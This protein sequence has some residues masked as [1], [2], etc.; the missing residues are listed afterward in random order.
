[1]K[2][3]RIY[4]A[5]LF[6]LCSSTAFAND[7]L[8]SFVNAVFTNKELSSAE[9]LKAIDVF[10]QKKENQQY[11][12]EQSQFYH[13][14]S[15]IFYSEKNLPLAISS[16]YRAVEIRRTYKNTH[17]EL[18]KKSLYNLG[19]FHRK[20]DETLKSIEVHKEILNE[21][22]EDR[23]SAKVYLDLGI[24]YT[25]IGDFDK[26]LDYFEYAKNY[27]RKNNI[28]RSLF[29]T[30]LQI[31]YTYTQMDR[32][33]YA[34]EILK[35]LRL[36]DSIHLNN[37]LSIMKENESLVINLRK[38]NLFLE[39]NKFEK[40]QESLEKAL[41][42][43][44][45]YND[46]M[47]LAYIH[48][49]L[50]KLHIDLKDFSKA[51]K[52]FE[53]SEQF[54]STNS[55]RALLSNMRA[56]LFTATEKWSMAEKEHLKAI[57]FLTG[58][59]NGTLP[60]ISELNNL[61]NKLD[62]LNYIKDL[63]NFY[64]D[65]H[66]VK[67]NLASLKKALNGFELADGLLDII[68]L[69]STE[70][71]SKLFWREQG[72]EVYLKGVKAAYLLNLPEKGFHF[73][74]KGKVVLLLEDL[75]EQQAKTLANIP[76]S[77]RLSE[78]NFKKSIINAEMLLVNSKAENRT[79]VIRDS[80]FKIKQDFQKFRDELANDFPKYA[81]IRKQIEILKEPEVA[82]KLLSKHTAVVEFVLDSVDGYAY[83]R[84]PNNR[85]FVKLD[86]VSVLQKQL[87]NMKSRISQPFF[88]T[89][90]FEEFNRLSVS[91]Y[92]K[93]FGA[94]DPYLEGTEHLIVI[95]DASLLFFPFEVLQK[96]LPDTSALPK[97]LLYEYHISYGLSMS[98]LVQND[99]L[100][101]KPQEHFLGVAPITFQNL[102][103]TSLT[104]SELE[105]DEIN[106]LFSGTVLKHQDANKLNVLNKINDYNV[107][108]FSTHASFDTKNRT[109]LWFEDEKLEFSELYSV[110]NQ[111]DL[112]VLSACKTLQGELVKGEGIMSLSRGF[113]KTGANSV[114][115]SLWN[116]NDKSSREIIVNFYNKLYQD[117]PKDQALSEAKK[118]YLSNHIGVE[119]SP[120]YWASNTLTGSVS[121][122][123]SPSSFNVF[124]L[125]IFLLLILSIALF[126]L[127]FLRR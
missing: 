53:K 71:V 2:L 107:L 106:R 65:Y 38:G 91:I 90:D 110:Q 74:E 88:T 124:Y 1:M 102:D 75:T 50:G 25:E 37:D 125:F 46:S 85:A 45:K 36:C 70:Q 59:E 28:P 72:T 22:K 40:S 112:V 13:D 86:S 83:F 78:M 79:N 62:L 5:L 104:E 42:V 23:Y 9:K 84:T 98:H 123:K 111:A 21:G 4:F 43:S 105:V 39:Q 117:L 27:F 92:R 51:E 16:L 127:K 17:P 87:S 93:L 97:Y 116:S 60:S 77:S 113:L 80:L 29:L 8:E 64:L 7:S 52:E 73:M 6:I 56:E 99:Q 101:R 26:A 30:H 115:A 68:R 3:S 20:N 49:S 82:P 119:S 33:G 58:N 41:L 48:S 12:L 76:D 120:Y 121:P 18:L 114:I 35:Q 66:Q 54:A 15:K 10:F 95:P 11:L 31:S 81:Q 122:L 44:M 61:T 63:S 96:A 103:L 19:L 34:N 118:E 47:G 108:H 67:P 32:L 126:L 109:W 24:I 55:A 100:S 57:G 69:E 89:T 94:I 14:I